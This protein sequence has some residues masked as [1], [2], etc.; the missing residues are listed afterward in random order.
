MSVF[1]LHVSLEVIR[2]DQIP[3]TKVINGCDIPVSA[4]T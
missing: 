2:W 3:E 1:C 4:R